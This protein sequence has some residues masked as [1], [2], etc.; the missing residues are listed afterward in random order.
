MSCLP[1][2]MKGNI[3]YEDDRTAQDT[4]MKKK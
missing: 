4:E 2:K 3:Y 1:E